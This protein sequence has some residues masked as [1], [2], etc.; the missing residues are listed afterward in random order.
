MTNANVGVRVSVL[1][2]SAAGNAV[3]VETQTATTTANGLMTLSFTPGVSC[4]GTP[5]VTDYDGNTYNTVQIG[6]QCWM[7]ENLKTTHYSDGTNI[8]LGSGSSSTSPFRYYPNDNDSTKYEYGLLYNW[9]AVMNGAQS[10]DSIPS[11]IQGVCP[12]GW[13]VPSKEE[14]VLLTDYLSANEEYLCNL[15]QNNIAAALSDTI[16]WIQP[17]NC[18]ECNPCSGNN[19]SGFSARGA[20]YRVNYATGF[21]TCTNYSTTTNSYG[22][23][24]YTLSLSYQNSNASMDGY[25]YPTYAYSVRCLK[26]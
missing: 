25:S 4:P 1:Q 9:A 18:Q 2:G 20:G 8:P 3:Y 16:G 13:H 15:N 21:K 12:N 22:D 14:F 26:D 6:T 17:Y 19:T 24:N 5:T 7:K 10:S 11:G 23:L